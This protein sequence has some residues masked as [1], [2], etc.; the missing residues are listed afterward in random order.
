MIDQYN[1]SNAFKFDK[2]ELAMKTAKDAYLKSVDDRV[3][4]IEEMNKMDFKFGQVVR[5]VSHSNI[6]HM[7][8]SVAEY[9]IIV[10]HNS[11]EPDRTSN[12]FYYRVHYSNRNPFT[13][14]DADSIQPITNW[15]EVP[16]E[17]K[18]YKIRIY[19]TLRKYLT[20]TIKTFI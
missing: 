5:I 1:V 15:D 12:H 18:E 10:G 20:H 19:I 4:L 8:G 14:V 13:G 11:L 17:L 3:R 6:A 2:L 7:L 16:D 9:G